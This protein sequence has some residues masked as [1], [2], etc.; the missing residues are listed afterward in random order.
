M[1]VSSQ[2]LRAREYARK[3]NDRLVRVRNECQDIQATL[4]DIDNQLDDPDDFRQVKRIGGKDTSGWKTADKKL[5]VE[6]LRFRA[7]SLARELLAIV[8]QKD[9]DELARGFYVGPM[10][11]PDPTPQR[12]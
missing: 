8:A 1:M 4:A 7:T 3:R 12:F 10:R 5:R 11:H 6:S 9:A 2:E